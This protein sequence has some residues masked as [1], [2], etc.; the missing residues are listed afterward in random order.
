M[1]KELTVADVRTMLGVSE[2]YTVDVLLTFGSHPKMK[3]YPFFEEALRASGIDPVFEKIPSAFFGDVRSIMTLRGRLWFDIIYG[4]AYGSEIVHVASLLGAKSIIHIGNTGGLQKDL[5][6]GDIVVPTH[7]VGDD[8]ATRM[9]AR[10]SVSTS[11]DADSVLRETLARNIGTTTHGGTLISIQAMFAE[12]RE[13]VTAWEQEGYAGVDLECAT[14]FAVANHFRIPV[15]AAVYV[16]DN[17]AN[18]SLLTDAEYIESKEHRQ[19]AKRR[20]YAAAV[21]TLLECM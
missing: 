11:F 10:P 16:A 3:E 14:V 1:Y 4:S 19:E 12:T 2:D 13:D 20:I 8:S 17:L 6:T 21:K 18:E 15:A 7:A 9:Y 5:R